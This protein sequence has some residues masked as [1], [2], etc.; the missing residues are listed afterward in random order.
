[1]YKY[2]GSQSRVGSAG[3]TIADMSWGGASGERRRAM[4]GGLS[5]H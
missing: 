2:P 5:L 4:D 3:G 1:M